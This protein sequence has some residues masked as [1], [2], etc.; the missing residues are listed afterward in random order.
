MAERK[1]RMNRSRGWA[2]NASGPVSREQ[3]TF[4]EG[5][6]AKLAIFIDGGYLTKIAR[7]FG[8]WMDFERLSGAIHG[9]ISENVAEPLDLLR[10]YYYDCLPWRGEDPTAEENQ[11]YF[12]ALKFF[13]ALRRIPRFDVREGRLQKFGNDAN[14]RPIVRQ[15]A[16]D[17]LL[18]MDIARLCLRG[19]ISH[20]VFRLHQNRGYP[21]LQHEY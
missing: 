19:R 8:I 3:R 18:G 1:G 11:R 21:N 16:V 5:R 14:G 17:L 13:A 20:E 10:T 15:N 7:S 4:P 6:M 2:C 9:R 12:N